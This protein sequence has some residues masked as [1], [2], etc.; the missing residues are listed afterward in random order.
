M[1]LSIIIPAYITSKKGVEDFWTLVRKLKHQISYERHRIFVVNDYSPVSLQRPED[2]DYGG[3][4]VY[5][6]KINYGVAV[7]RNLGIDW[8]ESDYIV[9]LDADDDVPDNFIQILD[10]RIETEL[11]NGQPFDII[12]FK[13]RHGDGNIAYPE[14]CAWGKLIKRSWIGKDRFDPDQLIGEEDTLFHK[15]GKTAKIDH[16]E[17]IIYYHRPNANPDSLM[18]RFWRGEVPR[19]REEYERAQNI[20]GDENIGGESGSLNDGRN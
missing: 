20:I 3:L 12:Q 14:P 13:A 7:A 1:K 8:T 9:F 5:K 2:I 16:D 15:E 17:R 18:K 6:T 10:D 11:K 4:D 19:R